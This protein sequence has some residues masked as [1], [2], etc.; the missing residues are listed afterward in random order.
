M[1]QPG[2]AR[3]PHDQVVMGVLQAIRAF[4]DAMDR[5]HGGL[6]G[7]MD[8]N[9]TD[10]AA[11]R[12]LI[13][14]EGRGEIVSPHQLAEH[15]RIS[16]ASTTKL[17]D[18][19]SASGHVA[20]QPHP[21]DRRSR[22]VVLTDESRSAFF[23]HFGERLRLMRGVAERYTDVELVLITGFLAEISET[24]DPPGSA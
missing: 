21:H 10:L 20:R 19:L 6:K 11:L 9:A 23:R 17:L 22:I 4:T 5:M 16:S 13:M 2:P 8:M 15:L 7:D 3:T 1:S 12:M 14:R 18:R 24:L